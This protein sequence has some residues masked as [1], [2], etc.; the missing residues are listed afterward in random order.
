MPEILQGTPKILN[1]G[2]LTHTSPFS[3][4]IEDILKEA[5]KDNS[6]QIGGSYKDIM[7]DYNEQWVPSPKMTAFWYQHPTAPNAMPIE[8]GRRDQINAVLGELNARKSWVLS[9]MLASIYSRDPNITMGFGSNISPD[10][11]VILA[12]T[13]Q[14]EYE[15]R[16]RQRRW[17]DMLGVAAPSS[18]NFITLQL[19]PFSE[20]EKLARLYQACAEMLQEGRDIA[21]V[22]IDHLEDLI[23]GRNSN[24][25][26]AGNMVVNALRNIKTN[27][28]CCMYY[29][30]HTNRGGLESNGGTGVLMDRLTGNQLLCRFPRHANGMKMKMQS[31]IHHAKSRGPRFEPFLVQNGLMGNLEYAGMVG[32]SGDDNDSI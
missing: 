31:E 23:P 24:D 15:I 29:A 10:A 17:F 25:T 13:E 6:V 16:K 2:D 14:D 20:T 5:T 27:T 7:V 22:A 11:T 3:D 9:T 4:P 26:K 21:V 1:K 19:E 28:K 8:L 32:N 18:T 30:H 12:D